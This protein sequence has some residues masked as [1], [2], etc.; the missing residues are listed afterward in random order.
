MLLRGFSQHIMRVGHVN[1]VVQIAAGSA[2]TARLRFDNSSPL[3]F[4]AV[5]SHI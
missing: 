2:F 3:K 4:F 1:G 5:I